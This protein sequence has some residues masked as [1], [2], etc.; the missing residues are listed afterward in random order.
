MILDTQKNRY[1][2]IDNDIQYFILIS[3]LSKYWYKESGYVLDNKTPLHLV[4]KFIRHL[5]DTQKYLFKEIKYII[6]YT[7]KGDRKHTVYNNYYDALRVYH[8]MKKHGIYEEIQTNF[9]IDESIVKSFDMYS[10]FKYNERIK[11]N[12]TNEIS[13]NSNLNNDINLMD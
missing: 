5:F 10:A 11:I 12:S 3:E 13:N 7:Y 1:I 8:K 6:Q 2:I 4:Y 9:D